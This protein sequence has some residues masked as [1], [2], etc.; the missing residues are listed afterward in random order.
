[1]GRNAETAMS[2]MSRKMAKRSAKLAKPQSSEREFQ[3]RVTDPT[4][5][6]LGTRTVWAI[7]PEWAMVQVRMTLPNDGDHYSLRCV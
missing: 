7:S 1:M 4:G 5:R 3:V 6:M 2:A